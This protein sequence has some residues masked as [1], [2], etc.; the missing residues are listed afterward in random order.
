M[1]WFGFDGLDWRGMVTLLFSG[2]LLVFCLIAIR[3]L[4]KGTEKR[5]PSVIAYQK[6]CRKL[7]KRG[8]VRDP[9][10]SFTA[11]SS[12]ARQQFPEL[13]PVI[14]K[15]TSL[16]QHLRYAPHPPGDS[17]KRLQWEIRKLSI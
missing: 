5:D 11:F 16:Y 12:R 15:I 8:L 7:A 3:L 17:L 13:G 9:A 14:A 2:M 4:R 1:S 6:F 10:E